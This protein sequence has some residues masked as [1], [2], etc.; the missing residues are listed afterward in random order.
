MLKQTIIQTNLLLN[1]YFTLE[2][3]NFQL[4]RFPSPTKQA[5]N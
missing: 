3:L 5:I 2:M 4:R 1:T